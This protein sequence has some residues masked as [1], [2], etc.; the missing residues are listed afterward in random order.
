MSTTNVPIT[1]CLNLMRR[2]PPKDIETSLT[3]LLNLVPDAT[4][5]LLQRVDQAT[6]PLA[7]LSL[8]QPLHEATDTDTGRRFLMCEYNRDANSYRSPWSNKYY[9]P[10]ED[11]YTPGDRLRKMEVYDA[12]LLLD[13]YRELYYGGGVSS[14]YLWDLEDGEGGGGSAGAGSFAGCFLVM[15]CVGQEGEGE[16]LLGSWESSHV[17]QVR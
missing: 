7:H 6:T 17:V 11:G 14:V 10:L 2:L 15:K 16:D 12:N 8:P 9:P 13:A 1:S 5:E 3:G 4:D